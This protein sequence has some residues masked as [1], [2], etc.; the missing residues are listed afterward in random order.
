[1]TIV[2]MAIHEL[3]LSAR[4]LL[5]ADAE[6]RQRPVG[7]AAVPGEEHREDQRRG[8]Q[9]G[10]VRDQRTDPPPGRRAQPVVQQVRDDQGEQQLRHGRQQEDAER[11]VER[12]PEVL[13]GQQP[14]EVLEAGPAVGRRVVEAPVAHGDDAVEQNRKE[15]EHA[16]EQEEGRDQEVRGALVVE[17][18][19]PQL[20]A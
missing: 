1:L 13:V 8:G 6:Q 3:H 11:V 10:D 12:V 9:R 16:E 19:P 4:Q 20:P 7:H 18:V 14:G 15:P 17:P 5:D 2:A